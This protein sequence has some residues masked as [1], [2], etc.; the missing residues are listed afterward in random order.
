MHDG[1]QPQDPAQTGPGQPGPASGPQ[2]GGYDPPP[3]GGYPHAA[4]GGFPQNP[5]AAPQT[6]PAGYGPPQ[7]HGG[8]APAPG[9]GGGPGPHGHPAAQWAG[10]ASGYGA[11][12]SEQGRGGRSRGV[13]IGAV[14]A[15]LVA[16]AAVVVAVTGFWVPGYFT[17]T[18]LDTESVENRITEHLRTGGE[19]VDVGSV[20]CPGDIRVRVDDTFTCTLDIDGESHTVT[21]T[22]LDTDGTYRVGAPAAR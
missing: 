18:V 12:V 14:V 21:S 7:Q 3:P 4:P 6:P 10:P 1:E 5:P 17:Y 19:S 15:A 11:P 22:I 16:I 2:H 9:F 13:L 8:F 20:A